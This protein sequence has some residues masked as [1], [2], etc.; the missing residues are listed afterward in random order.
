MPVWA[1][2]VDDRVSGVGAVVRCSE[3]MS[4]D[5][6]VDVLGID[7]AA[8]RTATAAL[9]AGGRSTWSSRDLSCRLDDDALI[10]FVRTVAVVGVDSPFEWPAFTCSASQGQVS[11]EPA[12]VSLGWWR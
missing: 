9:T 5:H 2:W 3:R 10:D 7:L 11:C 8:D 1:G 4:L 12:G 6:D